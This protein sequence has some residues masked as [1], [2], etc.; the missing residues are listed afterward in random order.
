MPSARS[1]KPN[2]PSAPPGS[3]QSTLVSHGVRAAAVRHP[4]KVA[5]AVDD[6]TLTYGRFVRRINQL[7]NAA[8]EDL[9]LGPGDHLAVVADN[10]CEYL[11]ILVGAGDLGVATAT[12]N[13]KLTSR[14]LNEVLRDCRARVVFVEPSYRDNIDVAALDALER[15]I[16]FG[17][18]YEAWIARASDRPRP[19][20]AEEWDPFCIPYTS[21]T[22]GRP[23][24]VLVPHRAR[25]QNIYAMAAEYGC[26]GPEQRFLSTVPMCHGAGFTFLYANLFFGGTGQFIRKFD[27]EDVLSI[28]HHTPTTGVFLVPTQFHKI[29]DLSQK[30]LD[31]FRR[32]RLQSI[33]SNAAPLPQAT[34]EQ[35]VDYF[36][37]GRLFECYGSTEAGVVSN[38]RPADQLRK[39][40][41][42]GH[43]FFATF[44][45]LLDEDR[46]EVAPG[47]VG[48]LFTS[49]PA[50]FNGYWQRPEETAQ[51]FLGDW[52]TVGD[53]AKRDEEGY[54]YIVDR[55]KDMVISGGINI[56]PR[57]V[58]EVI[59]TLPGV[60]EVAVIGVQD[61]E[62]GERLVAHVVRRRDAAFSEEQIRAHCAASLASFKVPK[63]VV[64]DAEL[65][66]NLSGKI[67]KR[68]LRLRHGSRHS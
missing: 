36:G 4:D 67:L 55:I 28:L 24:G 14:E 41:C 10:R 51:A 44:V 6:E 12:P 30:T 59:A 45:R 49:G 65:P 19:A 17:D 42:V 33:I 21:G 35:I 26:Y 29:F 58:E 31:R 13:P 23:K 47:E 25:T 60:R 8:A 1:S 64:F 18:E 20:L 37:E 68:E 22:T 39:Q 63:E 48:E 11:E 53:M 61:R 2:A 62:W 27:P 15:V 3:F 66:R 50:L 40:R 9:G 5:L 34:K 52:V 57:E 46:N 16:S 54:L 56:Y 7:I 32:N 38:L 43:P